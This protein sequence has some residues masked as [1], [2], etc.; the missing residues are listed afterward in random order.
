MQARL[1]R[2]SVAAG[3][4]CD[5]FEGHALVLKEHDRLLLERR[6]R[7]DGLLDGDGEIGTEAR[8][9]NLVERLRLARVPVVLEDQVAGDREEERPDR[10][11]RRIEASRSTEVNQ[12]ALLRDVL[13][14]PGVAR[15]APG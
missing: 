7:R 3:D 2:P 8:L 9:G 6:Q 10:A 11:A 14:E 13:R 5:L 1:D 12:K 4:L 15:Q